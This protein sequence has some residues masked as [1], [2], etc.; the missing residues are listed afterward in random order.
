[1]KMV[2]DDERKKTCVRRSLFVK[3]PSLGQR[4]RD[5][6]KIRGDIH[7][8]GGKGEEECRGQ[9]WRAEREMVRGTW[10]WTWL[11]TWD[12]MGGLEQTLSSDSMIIRYIMFHIV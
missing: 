11:G 12:G 9:C 3:V 2:L 6:D 5:R 7:N 1:M 10:P 4:M 8:R